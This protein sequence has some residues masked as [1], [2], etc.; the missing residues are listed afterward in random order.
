MK[1][2]SMPAALRARGVS[3]RDFAKFCSLMVT[4]LAFHHDTW[5]QSRR[6][7]RKQ[8]ARF[9]Y[10]LSFELCAAT[11]NRCCAAAIRPVTEFVL[12][13]LSWEYHELLMAGAGKQA[14]DALER[15]MREHPGEYIAVV[16]G[17]IP[18]ADGGVYCTIGGRTALDIATR[19]CSSAAAVIA[20]VRAPGMEDPFAL[21]SESNRRAWI[22]GGR[23]WV[24]ESD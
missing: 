3:R 17:A 20:V 24:E 11:R 2:N 6:R 4:T 14:E 10:G 15:V 19:V 22:T 1:S 18:T 21:Q 13:L 23:P 8:N 5:P 12:D 7:S 16:E 9:S